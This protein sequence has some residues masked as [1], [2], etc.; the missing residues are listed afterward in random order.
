M[1][2]RHYLLNMRIV[3]YALLIALSLQAL[4]SLS[5]CA[6]ITKQPSLLDTKPNLLTRQVTAEE[7]KRFK[8]GKYDLNP[9]QYSQEYGEKI[10]SR[11]HGKNSIFGM[12]VAEL[13]DLNDED[14]ISTR[15]V[16][17]LEV[18]NKYTDD[19]RF[20]ADF[21]SAEKL[22]RAKNRQSVSY[23]SYDKI[24]VLEGM[25]LDGLKHDE[26][27]YSPSLE[28]F[29]WMIFDGKFDAETFHE[30]YRDSYYD[31]VA[32][33]RFKD[34]SGFMAKRLR[35]SPI[36][37]SLRS[38]YQK[39]NDSLYFT[40]RVWGDMKGERWNDFKE[41]TSRL[42][43]PELI[44]HYTSIIFHYKFYGSLAGSARFAFNKKGG[45]CV[46]IEAFQRYCLNKAG[47]KAYQLQVPS[48]V[49]GGGLNWHAVT[50]FFDNE[51][52]YTMDNGRRHP[53]GIRPCD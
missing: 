2:L 27:R 15:D 25:T 21:A 16:D 39:A 37:R 46:E 50:K 40:L 35:S 23:D 42:N 38:R 1:W 3:G 14:G 53:Q 28:A 6:T 19:V 29:Y 18:I 49:G 7:L 20:P 44:D 11:L 45:N 17:V 13:P 5:G 51:K 12:Q 33:K 8:K 30:F 47:Y 48:S 24:S 22:N 4:T 26:V 43:L 41:V 10:V 9:A 31:F 34:S 32:K 36:A 52:C